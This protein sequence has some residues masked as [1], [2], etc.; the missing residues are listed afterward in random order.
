MTTKQK[1]PKVKA[2]PST[3]LSAE[4]ARAQS[5]L[6]LQSW[7]EEV[8]ASERM[9]V[10]RFYDIPKD[11]LGGGWTFIRAGKR[12]DHRAELFAEKM[13]RLGYQNAPRAVKMRG[14]EDFDRGEGLYLMIPTD[15][16]EVI[17]ERK[18]H[19]EKRLHTTVQQTF[20]Q[21]LNSVQNALGGR[22]TV[23]M[24]ESVSRKVTMDELI[25]NKSLK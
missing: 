25:N 1:A 10:G 5:M 3:T 9:A 4:D 15:V 13:R 14:F 7:I 2:K 18:K 20:A 17:I 11:Y 24:T 23:E 22:G 12:G 16:R 6:K 8:D 19:A 21:G